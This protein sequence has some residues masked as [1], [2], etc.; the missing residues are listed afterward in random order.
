MKITSSLHYIKS[1]G[2][3]AACATAIIGSSVVSLWADGLDQYLVARWTFND[4]TLKADH[5]DAVLKPINVGSNQGCEIIKGQAHL[6]PGTLLAT[7][8][9]NSSDKP[10][11][12]K[13]VTIW[14]RLKFEGPLNNDAFF[15]G[16]RDEVGPGDW[17]N[18]VFT[19]LSANGGGKTQNRTTFST[20]LH[21]QEK[22]SRG[23][24]LPEITPGEFH[25]ISLIFDGN[26]K[27]ST[28]LVDSNKLEH[29]HRDATSLDDFAGFG[30]G[31][32]KTSVAVP[33]MIIEEIRIYSIALSPEWIAEI[34][35][36]P[37]SEN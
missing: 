24:S 11:L 4:G 15:L 13:T 31:R 23:S 30:I 22:S 29:S 2:R 27:T 18:I 3:I 19:A 33:P 28:L 7:A 8:S 1:I 14:V 20:R 17:G 5:G 12:K 26:K 25:S 32:L 36:V 10:E 37:F 35:P 16:L 6:K 9:I 21:N 34:D